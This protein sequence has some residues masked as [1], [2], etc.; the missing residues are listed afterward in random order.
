MHGDGWDL[1][2]MQAYQQS[3]QPGQAYQQQAW[4][5]AGYQPN[6][7]AQPQ[8]PMGAQQG[9]ASMLPA[10]WDGVKK[11]FSSPLLKDVMARLGNMKALS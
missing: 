9:C 1:L 10:L 8:P 5:P 11:L 6:G 3:S 2:G 7:F 4:Q